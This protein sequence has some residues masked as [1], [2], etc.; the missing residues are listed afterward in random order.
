MVIR[1][2]VDYCYTNIRC[3]ASPRV[4]PKYCSLETCSRAMSSEWSSQ[5]RGVPCPGSLQ[6]QSQ[7]HE[8]SKSGKKGLKNIL[9]AQEAK[10]KISFHMFYVSDEELK[11]AA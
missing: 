7:A 11:P 8:Y 2:M 1:G 5:P 6:R 3:N 9:L 4:H 10:I